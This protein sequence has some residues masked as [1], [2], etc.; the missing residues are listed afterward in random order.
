MT[1]AFVAGAVGGVFEAGGV[2]NGE[3][4]GVEG[5]GG[6]DAFLREAGSVVEGFGLFKTGVAEGGDGFLEGHGVFVG[7]AV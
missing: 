1:R 5:V 6:D 2:L 3:A 4:V 7:P